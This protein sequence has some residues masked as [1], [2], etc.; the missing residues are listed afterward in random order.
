L[1]FFFFPL[2]NSVIL[3]FLAS[4][5]PWG[6]ALFIE[7]FSPFF[8]RLP[9]PPPLFLPGVQVRPLVS[10][11]G[12]PG[13]PVAPGYTCFGTTPIDPSFFSPNP[14]SSGCELLFYRTLSI[15]PAIL[16]LLQPSL[17]IPL[18]FFPSPLETLF[19]SGSP[20]FLFFSV[21]GAAPSFLFF[22]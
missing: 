6:E 8:P 12:C 22:V 15:S 7:Y 20:S 19:S 16:R 17:H 10:P 18:A 11:I 14:L 3:C 21:V 5:E 9:S 4:F 1:P 2:P 13:P